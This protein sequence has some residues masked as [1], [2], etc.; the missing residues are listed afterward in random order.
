MKTA[1]ERIYRWLDTQ[2]SVARYYGGCT[3]QGRR[4][5][6]A[7]NEPDQPLVRADVL[8]REAKERKDKAKQNKAAAQA[9]QEQ[10]I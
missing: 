2:L 4:Y 8:A 5:S 6:I 1:P 10:L 9:A 7:F 3:Y